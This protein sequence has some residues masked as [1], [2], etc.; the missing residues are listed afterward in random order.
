MHKTNDNQV[1]TLYRVW[2]IVNDNDCSQQW[3]DVL[4]DNNVTS[5]ESIQIV[6]MT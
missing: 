2:C 3:H 4:S 6:D 5:M 1:P